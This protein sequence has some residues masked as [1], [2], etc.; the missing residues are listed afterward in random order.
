MNPSKSARG[1]QYRQWP[2][3]NDAL[4]LPVAV[5]KTVRQFSRYHKYTLVS[6]L[7]RQTLAVCRRVAR[8]AQSWDSAQKAQHPERLVWQME[9]ISMSRTHILTPPTSRV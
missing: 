4:R 5:E 2:I 9:D 8:A 3:S 1:P 7:R 6:D